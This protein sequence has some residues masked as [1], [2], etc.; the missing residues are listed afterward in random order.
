MGGSSGSCVGP[1]LSASL[2]LSA[3]VSVGSMGS[4]QIHQDRLIGHPSRCIGRIEL[5]SSLSST[6]GTEAWAVLLV[7]EVSLSSLIATEEP[8]PSA[9]EGLVQ[10][11]YQ[12]LKVV[13]SSVETSGIGSSPSFE[14]AFDQH[15][16]SGNFDGFIFEPAMI[17]RDGGYKYCLHDVGW[18]SFDEQ[19]EDFVIP[20]GIASIAA[21]FFK[22]R[23]VVIDLWELHMAFFKLGSGSVF[24]L[25]VLILFRKFMQELVPY[26]WDIIEDWIQGVQEI[27]YVPFPSCNLRSVYEG[28]SK[29][30]FFDG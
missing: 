23:D 25:G 28:E 27:P 13:T 12:S 2:A 9:L 21:E 10:L 6:L 19:M 22:L 29:G 5:W 14:D 4:I 1:E 18:K 26:I 15:S 11:I 8:W 17:C 20:L 16:G 30:D 7:K 24:L 3:P